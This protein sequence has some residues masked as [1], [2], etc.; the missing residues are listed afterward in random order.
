M[1]FNWF[2]NLRKEQMDKLV[3]EAEIPAVMVSQGEHSKP[4]KPRK[5]RAKKKKVV[6]TPVEPKVDILKFEFD[7]ANPRLG[8][9]ELDWNSEFVELL[10]SHGYVGN[11]EEEIVDKW[12][13]DVC[14]NIASNQ[15]QGTNVRPTTLAGAN[16]IKRTPLGGGK[17]EIS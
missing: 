3:Q 1:M 4:K 12:L 2:K 9:I 15:Y 11:N 13:N 16:L 6:A 17:T 10:T 14:A 7:P 5:P 8:S